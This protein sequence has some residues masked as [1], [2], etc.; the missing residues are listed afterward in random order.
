MFQVHI[1][2]NVIEDLLR[3]EIQK[4]LDKLDL[5]QTFWDTADLKR[6]V[7]M[8]WST[9]QDT[10]FH[11]PDFPKAK[12][13]GKWYFPAKEAEEFLLVWIRRQQI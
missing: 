11:D 7:S 13:G 5:Q 3:D 4:R 10:F 12:V 9:I 1:D 6:Q 8:S 2:E